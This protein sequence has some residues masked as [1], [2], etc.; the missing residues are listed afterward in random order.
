MPLETTDF[1][2]IMQR[3][4]DSGAEALFAFLPSGP[5][6]L[7]FV[8]SFKDNGLKEKGIQFLSPGDLTQESDLPALGAAVSGVAHHV[9]LCAVA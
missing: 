8:K 6:T 3:A 5:T 9:P 1:S 2:P 7:G 4:R